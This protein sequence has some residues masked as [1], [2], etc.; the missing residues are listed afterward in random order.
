MGHVIHQGDLNL[1]AIP[2]LLNRPDPTILDI[3]TNNGGHTKA[4][5]DLFPYGLVH[6]FEPDPRAIRKFKSNLALYPRAKLYE[7][8]IADKDGSTTFY[9]SGGQNVEVNYIM[10]EGWDM[11]GSIRKPKDHLITNPSIK[12]DDSFEVTTQKL[13]TWAKKNQIQLIDFIWAD[14]QGAE[15]DLIQGG[16]DTLQNKTKYFYTEYSNREMY[17]GQVNLDGILAILTKFSIHTQ[18]EHDVLLQNNTL[19]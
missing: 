19:I 17:E 4:F 5:F 8:A 10:P 3:G 2:S 9:A 13:D 15:I 12:F 14:V 16:I 1:S 7:I 11:S 18:F 6:S